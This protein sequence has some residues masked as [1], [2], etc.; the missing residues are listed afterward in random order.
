MSLKSRYLNV[1]LM[2]AAVIFFISST[3]SAQRGGFY[4][5]TRVNTDGKPFKVISSDLRGIGRQDMVILYSDGSG[6][7]G[8][9]LNNGNGTYAPVVNY[10]AGLSNTSVYPRGIAVGALTTGGKPDIVVGGATGNNK[11]GILKNNGNGTFAA[12]TT[13]AT[14][15][16]NNGPTDALL[17][18]DVNGDGKLDIVEAYSSGIAH[19]IS[20]F[21]GTG[22]GTFPSEL[23]QSLPTNPIWMAAGDVN[24][25][26]NTD[27]VIGDDQKNYI[28]CIGFNSGVFNVQTPVSSGTADYFVGFLLADINGDGK[29]DIINPNTQAKSWSI[30]LGNGNG[31]FG[32]ATSTPTHVFSPSQVLVGDF[33]GDGKSDVAVLGSGDDGVE[34]FT[35][36]G[37]GT[38]NP[39]GAVYSVGGQTFFFTASDINGNGKLSLLVPDDQVGINILTGNGDG[40]FRG[41]INY[42]VPYTAGQTA[43]FGQNIAVADF[44]G[45]GK[46]DVAEAVEASSGNGLQSIILY[47]GNGDGSFQLG[48]NLTAPL[49]VDYLAASDVNGDGKMDLIA[50]GTGSNGVNFSVLLGNGNGTFAVPVT[51]TH[52]LTGVFSLAVADMNGDGKADI[53]LESTNNSLAVLLGNGNGTF[54]AAQVTNLTYG[55]YGDLAVGDFNKD[56][57]MDL[58]VPSGS[59]YVSILFGNGNGTFLPPVNINIPT[60]SPQGV[61]TADL[62]GDGNL[63]LIV[64]NGNKGITVLLGTA[65]GVFQAPVS[66]ASS[67]TFNSSSPNPSTLV[68]GD[69]DGD[70]K[71]DVIALNYNFGTVA[72]LKGNGDGT[73]QAPVEYATSESPFNGA[74]L[75]LNADGAVDLIIV[76]NAVPGIGVLMN[77]GG[78]KSTLLSSVP[79]AVY[80]TNITFTAT[81]TK[82]LPQLTA[83]PTGTLTFKDGL[84]TIGTG[85]LNASGVATF[86]TNGLTAGSHSI[87]AFFPGDANFQPNTTLAVP[88]TVTKATTATA[89]ATSS[90]PVAPGAPVTFTAT[91]T[92]TSA[93]SIGTPTGT[94]TFLDG[95]TSIGTGTLNASGVATLTTSTL[96]NG[97]HSITAS[98]G[99]DNNFS[100]SA[101]SALSQSVGIQSTTALTA[102]PN[103]ANFGSTVTLTATVT[104]TG[105]PTGS[106][107]FLDGT[108]SLG[109]ATLNGSGVATLAVSTLTAGTHN[110]TASYAGA[111]AFLP[112]TSSIVVETIN[113]PDYTISAN[114]TSLSLRQGQHGTSTITVTPINGFSGTIT[115]T[116]VTS[117]T[118][119]SCSFLPN[120]ITVTAGTPATT[121]L[122]ISTAGP[123]ALLVRPQGDGSMVARAF[124]IVSGGAF[125][126]MIFVPL[127]F[128]D[129]KRRQR[130]GAWFAMV[131]LVTLLLVIPGC[132]NKGGYTGLLT[133]T[134]TTTMN[135][136]AQATGSAGNGAAPHPFSITVTVTP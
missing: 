65:A 113:N 43:G 17:L 10:S 25:D 68:I 132:G 30:L 57:K 95:A 40:T 75:D 121:T 20:V 24:G 88:V 69:I 71:V 37:N 128:K 51:T 32:A 31:T 34:I 90:N 133:P 59:G 28:V 42:N 4:G 91:V 3:A 44:N 103:P 54:Q 56:G 135:I 74:A 15:T 52:G 29:L 27:L 72:V 6:N 45:D 5:A 7:V 64:A 96:A 35:G 62:N 130:I 73:F 118:N 76:N 79:T 117:L 50:V 116:C 134:G 63:D 81:F 33:N 129:R 101:S 110:L 86:T 16:A 125:F 8:V 67:A 19:K 107:S 97:V 112:S 26:G 9:A 124:S 104:S 47:L 93:G 49:N 85:I 1:F 78:T 60:S 23:S 114:P 2:I 115:F 127:A 55:I 61:K 36:L 111:G 123:N 82:G 21:L 14:A 94:V 84:T 70:G 83:V 92:D 87:T 22:N 53:I 122:T 66:Y 39:P 58:A 100:V 119:G 136:T 13:I 12:A 106:V 105:I 11:I 98:Y 80:G 126:G 41:G 46:L 48:T 102:S 89:L 77:T 18:V 131:L 109:S 108:T 120:P 99:G 38:F